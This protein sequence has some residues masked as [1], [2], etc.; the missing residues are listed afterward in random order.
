LVA[1]ASCSDVPTPTCVPDL[2]PSCQP[3][4]DPPTYQSLFDNILHPTC[5]SGSGTC[6]T[7]DFAPAGL[8]FEDA[9]RAY[10][11]LLGTSGAPPRVLPGNPA[12]SLIM[13]RLESKDPSFRMPPGSAPLSAPALCTFVQWIARGAQR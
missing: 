10:A 1:F 3:L 2:S 9:N 6:H 7:A 13:E 5:A 12:C 11:L 4:Y 8:V